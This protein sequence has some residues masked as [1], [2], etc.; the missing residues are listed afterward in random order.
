M[1]RILALVLFGIGFIITAADAQTFSG[2]ATP[3]MARIYFY[4]GTETSLTTPW[5]QVYINDQKVGSLGER[6]Y[7]FRDVLPGTYKI[8]VSSD[9]PYQEQYSTVTVTSNGTAFIRVF[10]V[11]QYGI[12]V[13]PGGQGTPPQIY[14]PSVFGNR[15]MD[16]ARAQREM[17]GLTSSGG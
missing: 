17:S 16:S 8:S 14:Q 2:P 9:V 1:R 15:L 5:P 12:Q 11:P 6:S 10:Y 7:F 3:T 13:F 4:R